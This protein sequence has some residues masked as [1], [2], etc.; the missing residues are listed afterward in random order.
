MIATRLIIPILEALSILFCIVFGILWIKNPSGPYEPP[1]A[2]A[3]LVL[4]IFEFYRRYFK[5]TSIVEDIVIFKK[6]KLGVVGTNLKKISY[7]KNAATLPTTGLQLYGRDSELKKLN[8]AWLS[9]TISIVCIVGWGGTGKTAIVNHWLH[10]LKNN[11][12]K[13]LKLIQW[14]FYKQGQQM[15]I[16]SS[17]DYFFSNAIQEFGLDPYDVTDKG[18]VLAKL[19]LKN[20]ALVILD[21]LEPLQDPVGVNENEP[22]FG[23]I[24]DIN[25]SSLLIQLSR[26][27]KKESAN[28]LCVITTRLDIADINKSENLLRSLHTI[29]LK[30]LAPSAG[31]SILKNQGVE[32]KIFDPNPHIDS[33]L[34]NQFENELEMTSN[35]YSGHPLALTLLGSAIRSFLSGDIR[36]RSEIPL[37]KDRNEGTHARRVI[38]AYEHWLKNT[39]E[40]NVLFVLG[41]FDRPT[42]IKALNSIDYTSIK[43]LSA[44]NFDVKSREIQAAIVT[45][46]DLNLLLRESKT[47]LIDCHPL[48]REYFGERFHTIDPKGAK[49]AHSD[50]F[51]YYS[52]LGLEHPVKFDDIEPFFA[53]ISHGC[54]AGKYKD[55]LYD[56]YRKKEKNNTWR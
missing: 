46:R 23:R 33:R 56:V 28:S 53:S 5:E 16:I 15:G 25:L 48:I 6:M 39:N 1:F 34:S 52:S 31:A 19:L 45:L 32:R 22:G 27:D 35:E 29:N 26:A 12:N 49:S 21:G 38:N 9:S 37:L 7:N 18:A 42:S 40:L 50:L 36:K 44:D 30:T 43:L 41:L 2:V 24:K 8:E 13:K 47:N 14:S 11:N 10:G 51:K 55:A 4:V 20:K 3:G 54:K 17:A